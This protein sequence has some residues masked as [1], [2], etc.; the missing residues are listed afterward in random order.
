MSLENRYSKIHS[1]VNPDAIIRVVP[2]HFA[3]THSHISYYVDM[4]IMKSRKSEAAAAASVLAYKY[5]NN[6]YID[7]II[8]MDGCEV[9]GAYLAEKLTDSGIMSMNK[10][11]TMYIVS[12]EVHTGGQLIFRD[13]MQLMI[14]GKHCLLLL[15][16]A[17]T[18][19]TIARA[20]ECIQYYGGIVEG[21][22]AIFSASRIVNGIE[23]NS[24][25]GGEDI[26]E[27]KTYDPAHCPLCAQGQRLDAIVNSYG[28]SKL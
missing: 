14:R 3:T 28:Y 1:T 26:P 6:T 17:T 16:S 22:S 13:N 18:G 11:Q 2:G 23:V 7:S 4:T 27:Y 9:I 12:P 21:V 8:C 19:R 25:F 10:H 5:T 15:A 24:I 20:L